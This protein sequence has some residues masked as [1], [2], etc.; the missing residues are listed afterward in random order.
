MLMITPA[1]R[2]K[3]VA[4]VKGLVKIYGW[5]WNEGIDPVIF[6]SKSKWGLTEGD[7]PDYLDEIDQ[8]L[9]HTA[10]KELPV[11]GQQSTCSRLVPLVILPKGLQELFFLRRNHQKPDGHNTGQSITQDDPIPKNHADG[12]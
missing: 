4:E 11:P 9:V 1:A 6:F 3:F 7:L 12:K 5:H 10:I 2:G 8:G